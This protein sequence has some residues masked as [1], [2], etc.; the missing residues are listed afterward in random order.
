MRS[1]SEISF[2]PHRP[3]AA[4][5]LEQSP[6]IQSISVTRSQWT[7]ISGPGELTFSDTETGTPTI[8][9]SVDGKYTFSITATNEVGGTS[10]K[11]FTLVYD[12]TKPS[13]PSAVTVAS[14]SNLSSVSVSYM[15]GSDMNFSTDNVKACTASN[16]LM[17]CL[18][19]TQD[20][21]SPV[22]VGSLV[23]GSAYYIR[24]LMEKIEFSMDG[25]RLRFEKS[26]IISTAAA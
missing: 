4:I 23:N 11:I 16:C 17:G 26:T 9:A 6:T 18:A 7:Q 20:L 21:A 19:E 25:P 24:E 13:T 8:T 14:H 3:Y 12:S 5:Q 15:A 2:A 10:T 22:T 1:I